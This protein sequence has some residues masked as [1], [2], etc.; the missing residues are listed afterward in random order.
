M[1]RIESG[2]GKILKVSVDSGHYALVI[3]DPINVNPAVA[4]A[5]PPV[6]G[7]PVLLPGLQTVG[8]TSGDSQVPVQADG[9]TLLAV[10]NKGPKTL[11]LVRTEFSNAELEVLQGLGRDDRGLLVES[12]DSHPPDVAFGFRREKHGGHYDYFWL[13]KGIISVNEDTT[14]TRQTT[15]SEQPWTAAGTFV[16]RQC[17]RAILIKMSSDDAKYYDATLAANWFTAETLNKLIVIVSSGIV[18][19]GGAVGVAANANVVAAQAE[20]DNAIAKAELED[21]IKNAD[22]TMKAAKS[23]ID[24]AKT[25]L[26]KL[27]SPAK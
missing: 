25:E 21:T 19:A 11:N 17:D 12:G 2:Q 24:A 10:V 4:T 18:G 1:A 9:I 5:R 20:L 7:E 27:T 6:Y 14:N 8:V 15:F 23:D 22:A 3:E 26:A 16:S 13:L